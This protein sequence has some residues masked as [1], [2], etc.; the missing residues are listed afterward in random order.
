[1]LDLQT[2][3]KLN[4]KQAGFFRFKKFE[5][6]NYL[7]TNDIGHYIFLPETD[8]KKYIHGRLDKKS[9]LYQKLKQK[10]FIKDEDYLKNF[11]W[12][13]RQRNSFLKYGPSLHIVVVTLRCNHRCIYCHASAATCKDKKYDMDLKTA[14]LVVDT[15]FKS[16]NNA[17]CIE[18]QGG[19]PLLNWPVVEFII[20]YAQEKNKLEKKNLIFRLVSNFTLLDQKKMN[21]LM[22]NEVN[23]CTSLDGDESTHNYNRIFTDGNSYKET[24]KWIK[25]INQAYK[26]KYKGKKK[27]YYRVGALITVTRKTLANYKQVIDTYIKLGFRNIYLRY[28]NPFGFALQAKEKIWYNPKEYIDFYKKAFDYILEKNYQGRHFYESM[29]ATY[30]RKILNQEEP[31]NLDFRSPCGAVIGQLAYNYNGD[32]YTCDEGRMIARMGGD[33]MFKLGNIKKNSLEELINNDLCKSVCFASCVDGLPGFSENVYKPY[34]G[35]CPVYNYSVHGNIFPAMKNNFR[36]QIDEAIV[37]YLFTKLQNRKNQ[38][39][40][41]EWVKKSKPPIPK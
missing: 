41:Q 17:I 8:F 38:D 5:N 15:I 32:V 2:I 1:M 21:F 10:L 16:N 29:A 24:V 19:E 3:K 13:Y 22:T 20:N 4:D 25:K 33:E 39:I 11:I 6:D 7:L 28:L 23:F 34:L 30:L 37:E 9:K 36:W 14:K 26:D 12:Q 35:I 18:F 31:N 40:F 27:N